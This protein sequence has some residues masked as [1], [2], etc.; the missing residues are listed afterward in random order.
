[1]PWFFGLSI[2]RIFNR[3]A[4][5]QYLSFG[6]LKIRLMKCEPFRADSNLCL[7][8]AGSLPLREWRRLPKGGS[9]KRTE[10]FNG[11]KEAAIRQFAVRLKIDAHLTY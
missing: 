10:F 3:Q 7:C 9:E 6:S 8:H 4:H 2:R 11:I 1:M 5:N